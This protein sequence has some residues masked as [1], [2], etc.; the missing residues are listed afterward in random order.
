MVAQSLAN[1]V[2]E[3]EDVNDKNR[4]FHYRSN[5]ETADTFNTLLLGAS[6]NIFEDTLTHS[7]TGAVDNFGYY[8]HKITEED[9][10]LL[11]TDTPCAKGF[12][13]DGFAYFPGL[14]DEHGDESRSSSDR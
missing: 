12:K 2:A 14:V 3:G 1:K 10:A 11:S 4:E 13:G 7:F 9:V 6:Y 8:E 5:R